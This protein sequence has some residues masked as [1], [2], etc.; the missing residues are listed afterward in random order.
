MPKVEQPHPDQDAFDAP[1]NV[2]V[3]APAPAITAAAS[4]PVSNVHT[5]VSRTRL[6]SS[7]QRFTQILGPGSI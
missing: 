7:A 4:A 3:P 2:A 5:R 6:R 1:N